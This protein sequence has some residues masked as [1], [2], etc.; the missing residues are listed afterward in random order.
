[1]PSSCFAD[2]SGVHVVDSRPVGW[3]P[4]VLLA[5]DHPANLLA[6]E[7]V[8]APL[9][10]KLVQAQSG[11]EA[12]ELVD[13]EP[14][15]LA[16]LDLRM[17]GIDGIQTA[18]RMRRQNRQRQIPIIVITAQ[19]PDTDEVKAAYARGVVDFLQKPF[20]PEV[21]RAKVAVFAE[22]ATQREKLVRYE[23]ALREKFEQQLVGIVSH[24]LRAPLNSILLGAEVGLRRPETD[25]KSRHTFEVT[26]AAAARAGRLIHDLLDYTQVLSGAT[27]PIKR[28]EVCLFEVLQKALEELRLTHPH[29][30]F[31]VERAGLTEG[32]W[33]PDRLTQVI[34]NLVANAATYGGDGPISLRIVGHEEAIELEV[35]NWG[36]AIPPALVP[37]LF[38]P[39]KRG[40][41]RSERGNI[42][43]GLFIVHEVARAH[44]GSVRVSSTPETG[45]TF[46]LRMPRS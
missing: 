26:K 31:L 36:E 35:H 23:A 10:L 15:A 24:D 30:E 32:Q 2:E 7:A 40:N 39:L 4:A 28:V 6:L 14:F 3:R 44:G 37:D 8:L 22:I 27:L 43:F 38:Q 9:D 5:D 19:T 29:R 16:L 42:G 45:T 17:P 1:M 21:L 18:E 20:L 12:L 11:A 25:A 33:D 34:T 13:R 46:S 41:G